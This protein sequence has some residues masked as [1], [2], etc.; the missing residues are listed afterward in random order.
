MIKLTKKKSKSMYQTNG[1]FHLSMMIYQNFEFDYNNETQY[2][3][4]Q[5]LF[6]QI[7][8]IGEN[9]DLNILKEEENYKI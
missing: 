3:G 2:K 5:W 4:Y 7:N 8:E 1:Y 6:N 9:R